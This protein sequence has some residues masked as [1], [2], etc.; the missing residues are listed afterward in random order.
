MTVATRRT[1]PSESTARKRPPATTPVAR[2]NQLIGLAYDLAEKQLREGTASS[3]VMTQFLKMGTERER[4]EQAKIEA[5]IK[6]A[7][8]KL[9]QMA[10]GDRIEELYASA[11]QAMAVYNGR[12]DTVVDDY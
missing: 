10:Q 7:E 12:D 1:T 8:G 4:K 6:L 3:Q 11:I 5:D 9:E 2:E